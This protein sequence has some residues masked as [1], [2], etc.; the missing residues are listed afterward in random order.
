MPVMPNAIYRSERSMIRTMERDADAKGYE[1]P[2]DMQALASP[3]PTGASSGINLEWMGLSQVTKYANVSKRTLRAW[4][5]SPV[6]PLPAVR[7]GGKHF[8][9]RSELDAWLGKHRVNSG[10]RIDFDRII[11]DVVRTTTHG[12]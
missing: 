3:W 12:R 1:A 10:R 7:V 9:R 5:H 4:I 6:D 11:E 8:V 2:R